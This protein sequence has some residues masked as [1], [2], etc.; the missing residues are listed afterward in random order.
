MKKITE[1]ELSEVKEIQRVNQE[2]A[3]KLGNLEF[4]RISLNIEYENLRNSIYESKMKESEILQ[5]LSDKYGDVMIDPNTGIIS[6][7]K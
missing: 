1:S 2:L 4:S 3:S 5:K 7:M 6:E